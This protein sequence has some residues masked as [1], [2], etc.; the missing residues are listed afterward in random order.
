MKPLI[1]WTWQCSLVWS[2]GEERGWSC[3][4]AIGSWGWW[5][6]E[7]GEDKEDVEKAGWGRKC[8]GWLEKERCT[9]PFKVECRRRHDCC[10]VETNLATLTC[11]GYYQS[12]NISISLPLQD[13]SQHFS[14][15]LHK[16]QHQPSCHRST[17]DPDCKTGLMTVNDQL[18][19][20]R[21]VWSQDFA[22]CMESTSNTA[23]KWH[24]EKLQLTWNSPRQR[25][26]VQHVGCWKALETLGLQNHISCLLA[27]N[28]RQ[29]PIKQEAGKTQTIGR[30][31][32]KHNTQ[33]TGRLQ[34]TSYTM[35]W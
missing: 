32:K 23:S 20:V 13:P 19:N 3:F 31:V 18:Q 10:C 26:K 35:L 4:E 21:P 33:T 17:L 6:K 27:S 12:L 8:E 34:L 29:A 14:T 24:K 16:L 5:S 22:W 30:P 15:H 1:S 25:S 28:K 2:C 9:L 11:W 7:E